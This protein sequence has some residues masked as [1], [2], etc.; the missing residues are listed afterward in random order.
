VRGLAEATGYADGS[1]DMVVFSFIT[2]ECPQQALRDFVK[3]A[4]RIVK[5][6]G[7]VCCVD[8]DPRCG[9]VDCR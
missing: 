5:T 9:C 4:R 2:H 3:E 8:L 1:W 6:G 7:V